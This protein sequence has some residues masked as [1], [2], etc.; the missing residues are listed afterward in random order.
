MALIAPDAPT[1]TYCIHEIAYDLHNLQCTKSIRFVVVA[2]RIKLDIVI[3]QIC[4][5]ADVFLH[6]RGS[7]LK[8][9]LT[10]KKWTYLALALWIAPLSIGLSLMLGIHFT[11]QAKQPITGLAF[12][13]QIVI[14]HFLSLKCSCSKHLVQ[15]LL[16]RKS[17]PGANEIIHLIHSNE[18]VTQKLRVAGYSVEAIDDEESA[19]KTYSLQVLPQLLINKNDVVLYQ[20]GYGRDQ[21]HSQVYEDE[22]IIAK[23][24]RSESVREFPI[25]GCANGHVREK[26]FDFLGVKYGLND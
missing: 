19:V 23:V 16:A 13:K 26:I 14:H 1:A 9:F 10:G 25:F 12:S 7:T 6:A 17:V 5:Q 18:S 15:H 2:M 3:E 4:R 22:Q 21:Q 24:A 20:G 11:A 8:R